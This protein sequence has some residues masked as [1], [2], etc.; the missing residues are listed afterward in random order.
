MDGGATG[1]QRSLNLVSDQL[2]ETSEDP[3]SSPGDKRC[4][5]HNS[6]RPAARTSIKPEGRL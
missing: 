5:R 6:W 4:G 3:G 2:G 1:T